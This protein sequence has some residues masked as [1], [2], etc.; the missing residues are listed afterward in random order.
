MA[1][2]CDGPATHKQGMPSVYRMGES[3]GAVKDLFLYV[4]KESTVFS[5][6]IDRVI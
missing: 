4:L 6:T 2:S 3:A 1:V 5:E